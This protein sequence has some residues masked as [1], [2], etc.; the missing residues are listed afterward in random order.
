MHVKESRLGNSETS[1]TDDTSHTLEAMPLAYESI[2]KQS[3]LIFWNNEASKYRGTE[4]GLEGLNGNTRNG[5]A[6][7]NLQ[8]QAC[9]LR[10]TFTLLCDRGLYG[11]LHL[12]LAYYDAGIMC[13]TNLSGE[14]WQAGF[15]VFYVF[16]L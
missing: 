12:P 5:A 8:K 16:I 14:I 13:T 7:G 10:H 2:T 9:P 3:G 4:W 11:A 15:S 6:G 1:T